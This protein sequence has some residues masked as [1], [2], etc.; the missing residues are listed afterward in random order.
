MSLD[1]CSL[2]DRSSTVELYNIILNPEIYGLDIK[3][4]NHRAFFQ[5]IFEIVSSR[6][7]MTNN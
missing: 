3:N 1:M 4:E 6:G 5:F 7:A 2:I